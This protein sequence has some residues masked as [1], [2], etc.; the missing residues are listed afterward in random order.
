MAYE[1]CVHKTLTNVKS[2]RYNVSKN[3]YAILKAIWIQKTH[4][5]DICQHLPN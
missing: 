4:D 3:I 1:I 5:F 2:I